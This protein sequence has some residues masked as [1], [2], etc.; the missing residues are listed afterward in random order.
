[1][2]VRKFNYEFNGVHYY[3][4]SI[5]SL[6]SNIQT[7]YAFIIDDLL[8][9]T[10]QRF[11]RENVLK[12]ALEHQIK[13]IAIT[14]HHEDH[15]GNVG[16][17][18]QT[19]QADAYAHPICVKILKRGYKMSPLSKMIS[20]SVDKALLHPISEG[21][22]I[23]TKNYTILPIYTPGHCDDHYCYYEKNNG[24]LFS[25]DLYV[26]DKIKYFVSNESV[27]TQIE[28]IKK[29]LTLDF[30]SLFCSHN[31]KV[32][33]GKIRLNNKLQFF[34]DFVG[35]VE[36][37]YQQGKRSKE[38]LALMNMKENYYYKVITAGSF[39]SENMVKSVIRDI[40]LRHK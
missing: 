10:A 36:Q 21:E 16:Y 1:M 7:V 28:S 3:R 6:G 33:N 15:T 24:W 18:M 35:K 23:D 25:G 29:L 31:P 22:Q 40:K 19:L 34:E 32:E 39:T 8:I 37:H 20:G 38:I 13:K 17:L 11:N 5:Y 14:H 12:V 4:F 26:A 2:A 27:Y 9:D 30:D